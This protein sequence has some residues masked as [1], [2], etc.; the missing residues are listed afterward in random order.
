MDESPQTRPKPLFKTESSWIFRRVNIFS[1]QIFCALIL[2][3]LTFKGTDTRLNETIANGAYLLWGSIATGYLFGAIM[4]DK[5]QAPYREYRNR[6]SRVS[7]NEDVDS[8]NYSSL[9]GHGDDG[10]VP[11]KNFAG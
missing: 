2:A 4:D 3:Y 11:P 8:V 6:R 10:D 1:T 5:F 9:K 7:G